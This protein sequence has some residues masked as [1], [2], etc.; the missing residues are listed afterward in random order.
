[1]TDAQALS[2]G[3]SAA[4][5]CVVACWVGMVYTWRWLAEGVER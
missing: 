2:F 4:A 3:V 1:M 5:V